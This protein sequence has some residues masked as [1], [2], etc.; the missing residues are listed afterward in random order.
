[1]HWIIANFDWLLPLFCFSYCIFHTIVSCVN[2]VK[3]NK[4]ITSLCEKCGLPIVENEEHSCDE[5]RKLLLKSLSD[6]DINCLYSLLNSLI[7]TVLK[8]VYED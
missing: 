2:A 4:K 3:L 8:E 6:S 1:M 5:K 7:D